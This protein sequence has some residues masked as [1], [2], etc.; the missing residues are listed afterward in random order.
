MDKLIH[1]MKINRVTFLVTGIIFVFFGFFMPVFLVVG[2]VLLFMSYKTNKKYKELLNKTEVKNKPVEDPVRVV[3][4]SDTVKII[5]IDGTV[6]NVSANLKIDDPDRVLIVDGG[7]TYHTCISC[8]KKWRLEMR[9][10]FTGWTLIKK[11]D[12]IKSG[13]SYC[14]FCEEN[15]NYT[16]DDLLNDLDSDDEEL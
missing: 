11:E 12:V 3:D 6:H 16:L 8:Y 14:K 7:K 1:N 15:D 2:G 9:E 4:I 5:D 10:N 13:M